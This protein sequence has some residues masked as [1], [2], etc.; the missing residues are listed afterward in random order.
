MS[1]PSSTASRGYG[2]NF[3]VVFAPFAGPV[4]KTYSGAAPSSTHEMSASRE[5]H[6]PGTCG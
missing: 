2:H 6:V 4:A 3:L 5:R 1:S